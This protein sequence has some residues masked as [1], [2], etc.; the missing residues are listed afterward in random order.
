[1]K[2]S[3]IRLVLPKLVNGLKNIDLH[4]SSGWI[5]WHVNYISVKGKEGEREGASEAGVRASA[6]S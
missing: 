2:C 5:V 4:T 3:K 1:M 6:W